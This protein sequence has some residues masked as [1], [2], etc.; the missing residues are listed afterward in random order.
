MLCTL[1]ALT[2]GGEKGLNL[3]ADRHISEQLFAEHFGLGHIPE[4]L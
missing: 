3:K 2:S 1:D 4:R